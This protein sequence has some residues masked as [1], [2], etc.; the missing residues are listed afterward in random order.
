MLP[1]IFQLVLDNIKTLASNGTQKEV[2]LFGIGE[3]LLNPNI[4]K[5]VEMARNQIPM[6]IPLHLNTNGNIFNEDIARAIKDAGITH[7]TITDHRAHSTVKSMRICDSVGIQYNVSRDP[8]MKPNNWAGQVDWFA[9]DYAYDCQWL[10]DGQVAVQW[11]GKISTCCID[12]RAQGI[13]GHISEDLSKM[14]LRPHNLCIKC[15]HIVPASYKFTKQ[16]VG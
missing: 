12:S 4:I 6:R 8:I 1:E 14:E 5:F 9:P 3:P 7:I 13:V 16:E 15:H 11:D 10:R 2:N